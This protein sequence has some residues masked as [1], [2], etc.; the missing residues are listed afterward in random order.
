METEEKVFNDCV[1][2]ENKKKPSGLIALT[3]TSVGRPECRIEVSAKATKPLTDCF[4]E[5][6]T[7][8]CF[9][10]DSNIIDVNAYFTIILPFFARLMILP[11]IIKRMVSCLVFAN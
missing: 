8:R 6:A 1:I 2:T 3:S 5:E 4:S 11:V 7:Y 9:R 10:T